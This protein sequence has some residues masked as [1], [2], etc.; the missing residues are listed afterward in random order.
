[1]TPEWQVRGAL[2]AGLT[3][4]N[5]LG[6]VTVFVLALWVVPLPVEEATVTDQLS[7]VLAGEPLRN[8]VTD[9]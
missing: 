4:S 8:V 1:M 7:R 6:I 5:L 3:V 2:T 9:Y